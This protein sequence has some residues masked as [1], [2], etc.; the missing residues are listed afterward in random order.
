MLQAPFKGRSGSVTNV[1]LLKGALQKCRMA[2]RPARQLSL[3]KGR[4]R[5]EDRSK[6]VAPDH[7]D[8]K[9]CRRASRAIGIGHCGA[10]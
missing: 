1:L 10:V 7:G 9:P 3:N 6:S 4:L 2:A 5:T 8:A